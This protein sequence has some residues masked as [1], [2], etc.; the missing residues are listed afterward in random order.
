MEQF[1]EKDEKLFEW[2]NEAQENG[3]A[4]VYLSLG[5]MC[6]WTEWEILALYKGLK[7]LKARVIW[8]TKVPELH[9][10]KEDPDWWITSWAPQMEILAHPAMKVG[11]THGGFGGVLEFLCAGKPMVLFPHFGDQGYNAELIEK[12][13]CGKSLV[14]STMGKRSYNEG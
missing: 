6:S 2:M 13:G 8:S 3:Q 1:K 10:N 7:N 11:L 5:S 14:P 12:I 4:V 9:P